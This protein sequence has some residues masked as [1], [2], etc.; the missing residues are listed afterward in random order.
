MVNS[1]TSDTKSYGY[2]EGWS[3][4]VR[5]WTAPSSNPQVLPLTDGNRNWNHPRILF[6]GSNEENEV[7]SFTSF[8]EKAKGPLRDFNFQAVDFSPLSVVGPNQ[9]V[10][11]VNTAESQWAPEI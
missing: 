9:L 3:P 8:L 10:S 6:A 11:N 7:D 2:P 4:L 5:W 1:Q